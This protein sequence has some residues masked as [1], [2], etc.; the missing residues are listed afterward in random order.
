MKMKEI[1]IP[2]IICLALKAT[3][4]LVDICCCLL[5]KY[6]VPFSLDKMVFTPNIIASS[7]MLLLA[8]AFMMVMLFYKGDSRKTVSW[9]MIAVYSVLSLTF[10]Y[11]GLF[12]I[13]VIQSVNGLE[14]FSAVNTIQSYSSIYTAPF[15][16]GT[17]ICMFIAIGRY[18][19]I[20]EKT[21]QE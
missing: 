17:T 20:T 14:Y 13:K 9:I 2:M 15:S 12:I 21:E 18:S 10:T 5:Q 7:I 1:K 11:G 3:V 4:I 19:V 8:G 16:L 6:I